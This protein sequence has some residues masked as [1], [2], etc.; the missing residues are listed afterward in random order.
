MQ[1]SKELVQSLAAK[2]TEKTTLR[3]RA[4]VSPAC[5]ASLAVKF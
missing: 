2:K 3:R 5:S 1:S 4:S